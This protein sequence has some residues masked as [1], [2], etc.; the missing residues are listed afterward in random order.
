MNSFIKTT[1]YHCNYTLKKIDPFDV[2]EKKH[3]L[4][5]KTEKYRGIGV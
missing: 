5:E 1:L 4:R 2:N 3:A